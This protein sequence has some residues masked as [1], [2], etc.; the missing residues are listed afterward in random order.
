MTNRIDNTGN[1]T[2]L[3]SPRLPTETYTSKPEAITKASSSHGRALLDPRQFLLSK[4][5]K[6]KLRCFPDSALAEL[7][8]Q[9][10][11]GCTVSAPLC[12][13]W[14]HPDTTLH[15]PLLVIYFL[16]QKDGYTG[17]K[18]CWV[19]GM[20]A[21]SQLQFSALYNEGDDTCRSTAPSISSH[22]VCDLGQAV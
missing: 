12:P 22:N 11:V 21:L 1:R 10:K 8:L 5:K 16:S 3:S 7:G 4:K 2:E 9:I 20:L 18:G 19:L 17:R 13:F 14:L 6:K 15:S